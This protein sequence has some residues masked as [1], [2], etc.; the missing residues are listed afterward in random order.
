MGLPKYYWLVVRTAFR[1]SLDLTQYVLFVAFIALGAVAL[2][3]PASW[4]MTAWLQGINEWKVAASVLGAIFAVRLI[5]APY[6]L[7]REKQE[8][9]KRLRE[10]AGTEFDLAI[11]AE[12]DPLELGQV[13]FLWCG[14]SPRGSASKAT[15]E[16]RYAYERLKRALL[17]E[18]MEPYFASS[19]EKTIFR[20]SLDPIGGGP[21]KRDEVVN[22]KTP[23]PLAELRKFAKTQGEQ[24]PFLAPPSKA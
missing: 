17:E 2:A 23:V 24:P 19:M 12:L 10:S 21:F 20:M 11:W 5:L 8:E 6:W 3:A 18:K 15:P 14:Q 4:Q 13:A 1:H 7:H 16:V 9:I 22:E